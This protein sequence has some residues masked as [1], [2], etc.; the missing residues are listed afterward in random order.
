MWK[1]KLEFRGEA[2]DELTWVYTLSGNLFGSPEGYGFQEEVRQRIVSGARRVVIDLAAVDRIDSSGVGILVATMWS[3]SQAGAGL[4]LAALS[5][6]VEKV[7]S[8]AMLLDHI[9]HAGSVDEALTT[10]GAMQ[11]EGPAS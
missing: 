11:L 10:L 1:N 3:A 2:R 7:L 4:V 9:D 6:K 5:P 8:I